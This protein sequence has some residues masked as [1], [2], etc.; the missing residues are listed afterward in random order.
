MACWL[1]G[2]SRAAVSVCR[3]TQIIVP[4]ECFVC[5][6]ISIV[7]G[8]EYMRRRT[9]VVANSASV[10]SRARCVAHITHCGLGGYVRCGIEHYCVH[11][12]V[13]RWFGAQLVVVVSATN[14]LYTRARIATVNVLQRC[15]HGRTHML[16]WWCAFVFIYGYRYFGTYISVASR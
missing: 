15:I 9:V 8:D 2:G 1:H 3:K 13:V 14:E 10:E 5:D 12:F 11:E 16:G 4:D 7:H 6:A